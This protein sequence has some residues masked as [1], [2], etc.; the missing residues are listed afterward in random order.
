MDKQ[1]KTEYLQTMIYAKAALLD[2]E[3]SG[4]VDKFNKL[5]EEYYNSLFQASEADLTK[6]DK[7]SIETM[8]DNFRKNVA[9][10]SLGS[11]KT[12]KRTF[13][14]SDFADTDL[15]NLGKF[16]KS[17]KKNKTKRTK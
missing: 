11:F 2:R 9:G 3:N 13:K 10:K 1:I 14:G 5:L 15:M 16:A 12:N 7:K 6:N 17:I 4:E 8:M